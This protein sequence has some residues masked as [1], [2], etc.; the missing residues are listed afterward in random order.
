MFCKPPARLAA[1]AAAALVLAGG[2]LALPPRLPHP[3]MRA[4]LH[5]LRE[6]RG[7]LRAS[8]HDFGGH[9]AAALRA[10]DDAIGSIKAVVYFGGENYRPLER[11]PD[12]YRRYGDHPRMR[13]ALEDL[14]AARAEMTSL[15]PHLNRMKRRALRDVDAAI[16]ELETALRFARG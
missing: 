5:E 7:E 8:A 11:R 12:F 2:T 4:A 10:V 1:L 9:R 13:Q 14:R 6:A 3:G 16:A 15:P